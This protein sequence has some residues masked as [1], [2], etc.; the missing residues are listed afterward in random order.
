[1]NWSV[2]VENSFWG[3]LYSSIFAIEQYFGTNTIDLAFQPKTL[4]WW[5][6]KQCWLVS[7]KSVLFGFQNWTRIAHVLAMIAP[8]FALIARKSQWIARVALDCACIVLICKG[9]DYDYAS[10]NLDRARIDHT[11]FP[12][13]KARSPLS[14]MIKHF[15]LYFDN[16][17]ISPSD[18]IEGKNFVPW[19]E[20]EN[21]PKKG[22][23]TNW[24]AK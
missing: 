14:L 1:M 2:Q 21:E 17:S 12:A 6:P 11:Y 10:F 23:P 9:I 22:T 16:L 18:S 24:S 13:C 20:W 7:E 19:Y 15:G 3:G 5:D 8:I 4:V